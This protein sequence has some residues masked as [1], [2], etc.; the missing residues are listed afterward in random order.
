MSSRLSRVQ[1]LQ[2]TTTKS[3]APL[4]KKVPV[5]FVIKH[6]TNFQLVYLDF[7][8]WCKQASRK[9]GSTGKTQE[10]GDGRG[11]YP[12]PYVHP[13]DNDRTQRRGYARDDLCRRDGCVGLRDC[14]RQPMPDL[15]VRRRGRG[16]GT[17]PLPQHL[18]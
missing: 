5:T 6:Q 7:F 13:R 2:I 11:H 4:L 1:T 14:R 9:N 18:H 15:F 10:P 3:Q 16:P 8:G 17:S 12:L